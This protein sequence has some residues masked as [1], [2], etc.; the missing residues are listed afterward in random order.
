M[1]FYRLT[2]CAYTSSGLAKFSE[3]FQ[4]LTFRTNSGRVTIDVQLNKILIFNALIL[5]TVL[6][7]LEFFLTLAQHVR[8]LFYCFLMI[9]STNQITVRLTLLLF[10]LIIKLQHFDKLKKL[11][12]KFCS[13]FYKYIS[14]TFNMLWK[15]ELFLFVKLLI[16][17][18][19][20]IIYTYQYI[21]GYSLG[22]MSVFSS[23][24]LWVLISHM[25]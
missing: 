19:A 20:L 21:M 8:F 22:V 5:C 3:L 6:D 24:L 11:F 12:Y 7:I 4:F 10:P 15:F 17:I 23:F 25:E 18:F 9:L 2:D 14:M 1:L 16:F 13:L